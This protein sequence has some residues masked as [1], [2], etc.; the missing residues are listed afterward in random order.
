MRA[1]HEQSVVSSSL[2]KMYYQFWIM[3]KIMSQIHEAKGSGSKLHCRKRRVI[4]LKSQCSQ[5]DFP[6]SR[7]EHFATQTVSLQKL[8]STTKQ[9]ITLATSNPS[10]RMYRLHFGFA[11]NKILKT[12][13][14]H[15]RDKIQLSFWGLFRGCWLAAAVFTFPKS[16]PWNFSLESR[17]LVP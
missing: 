8:L 15:E 12:T 3:S 16:V 9:L 6:E 11:T 1:V 13:S 5:Q 14:I 10:R 17:Y 2:S 7:K 4:N